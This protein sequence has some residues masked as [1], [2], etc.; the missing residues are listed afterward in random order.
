MTN[1]TNTIA[2]RLTAA[3]NI[4]IM[5]LGPKPIAETISSRI[6]NTKVLAEQACQHDS[7]IRHTFLLGCG[8]NWKKT[9][10]PAWTPGLGP[11]TDSMQ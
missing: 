5:Q 6:I 4:S 1:K 8:A 9:A 3:I 10:S 2:A 7:R 11:V